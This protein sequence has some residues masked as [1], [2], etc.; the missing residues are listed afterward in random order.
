M[1]DDSQG[2]GYSLKADLLIP[3]LADEI[4]SLLERIDSESFIIMNKYNSWQYNAI[5]E[6]IFDRLSYNYPLG[7]SRFAAWNTLALNYSIICSRLTEMSYY[8]VICLGV[9][10]LLIYSTDKW[11]WEECPHHE[12]LMNAMQSVYN[13]Y[14]VNMSYVHTL[15]L[16]VQFDKPEIGP[17][18]KL[19][20]DCF[21][22]EIAR[23]VIEITGAV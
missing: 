8:A 22:P 17:L 14:R 20:Q 6:K 10:D 11:L 18:A 5:I 15:L 3:G 16:G 19:Y 4:M 13:R 9:N 1:N 12:L 23:I 7:K 2:Y 21:T